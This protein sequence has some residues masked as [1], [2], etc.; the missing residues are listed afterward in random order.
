MVQPGSAMV[1]SAACSAR[2]PGPASAMTVTE[3]VLPGRAGAATSIPTSAT[4][5]PAILSPATRAGSGVL[6]PAP[7]IAAV[8]GSV[9]SASVTCTI[10]RGRAAGPVNSMVE[11]TLP[12]R[13]LTS[14]HGATGG[15]GGY[16]SGNRLVK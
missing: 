7:V 3:R 6:T 5:S 1:T 4:C 8:T 9:V 10:C 14:S 15:P 13:I 16:D 12:I 11:V 2:P